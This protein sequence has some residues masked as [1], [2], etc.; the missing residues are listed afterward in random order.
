MKLKDE[1]LHYAE[2]V[3]N[4]AQA[5][6]AEVSDHPYVSMGLMVFLLLGG[7]FVW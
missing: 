4:A 6:A 7:V 5:L 1:F 2:P 3:T